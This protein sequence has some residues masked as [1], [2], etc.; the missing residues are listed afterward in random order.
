MSDNTPVEGTAHQ[1]P[2]PPQA[3][4]G[5]TPPAQTAP[6]QRFT[7]RLWGLR[8]VIAV[9][10]ASVIIGGLG[11]AALASLGGRH[12]DGRSGPGFGHHFRGG[13]GQGQGRG[14][15]GF[16]PPGQQRGGSGNDRGPGQGED[17]NS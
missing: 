13:P 11:G 12:D 8:A 17:D 9:A 7:D 4:E 16:T 10:I 2:V 14:P 3:N 5:T 6:K 1:A 15:N